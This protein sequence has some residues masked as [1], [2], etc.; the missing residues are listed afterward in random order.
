MRSGDMGACSWPLATCHYLRWSDSWTAGW[1]LELKG[2][3][4]YCIAFHIQCDTGPCC[5]LRG[6]TGFDDAILVRRSGWRQAETPRRAPTSP[7]PL[8]LPSYSAYF[9]FNMT[10]HFITSLPVDEIFV[11]APQRKHA[12]TA[13]DGL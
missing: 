5:A 2:R 12:Q 10:Y 6:T 9:S 11:D 4:T 7:R 3:G 13:T 1:A 8:K